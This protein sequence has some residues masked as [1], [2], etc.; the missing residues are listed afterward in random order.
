MDNICNQ[1]NLIK[2]WYFTNL[3]AN[4]LNVLEQEK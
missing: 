4:I 2:S 3:F 1:I